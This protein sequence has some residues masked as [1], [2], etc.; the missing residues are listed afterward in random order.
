MTLRWH[1]ETPASRPDPVIGSVTDQLYEA[2]VDINGYPRTRHDH[3]ELHAY[4][5]R[6]CTCCGAHLDHGEPH[7]TDCEFAT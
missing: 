2:W 4:M 7:Q 1:P 6:Y 3:D 5:S